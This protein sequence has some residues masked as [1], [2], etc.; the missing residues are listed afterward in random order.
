MLVLLPSYEPNIFRIEIW[1]INVAL[2]TWALFTKGA[3]KLRKVSGP[4]AN[5]EPKFW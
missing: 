5:S 2:S 1:R 4:E 3:L